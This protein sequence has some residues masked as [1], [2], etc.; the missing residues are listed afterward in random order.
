M[1]LLV[2]R[3]VAAAP[4]GALVPVVRGVSLEID[5]G[6]W[7]ALTGVNGCGKST[8]A[9]ALAGLLPLRAGDV[10]LAGEPLERA[11]ARGEIGVVLQEPSSQLLQPTVGDELAFAAR[12]LGRPDD[13][14]APRLKALSAG[15]G[16]VDDL[17]RDPRVLSAGRQQLVLLGAALVSE[18]RLLVA[19][20]AGAHL[21]AGARARA[22][23]LLD[24][25]V[26]SGLAL[27][28]VTQEATERA[29]ARR[30]LDLGVA[31]AGGTAA[32][33]EWRAPRRD[34]APGHGVVLPTEVALALDVAPGGD[35]DG[36]CVQTRSRLRVEVRTPG[37]TGLAGR[38]GSGKSVLLAAACGLLDLPQIGV[39]WARVPE[40]PPILAAQYPELQIFEERVRDEVAF[41]AVSRGM[42]RERALAEAQQCFGALGL[43]GSGFLGT[44]CWDLSAGER[45]L[46][47]VVAALV[48]PASLVAL[49]EPTAGLDLVRRESLAGM[50]AERAGRDPVLIASQDHPW[51]D[52]VGARTVIVGEGVSDCAKSQQKNGLTEPCRGV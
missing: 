23:D 28:W 47:E 21:D 17:A 11:R 24:R 15:L 3:G 1:S 10:T 5:R 32:A 36:P 46:L 34:A 38:N 6:E 29:R 16:L 12:N 30:T 37:I 2:A 51:L 33:G 39:R 50:V 26:A 14:I 9:L 25:E 45:R 40:V 41:A 42:D 19:D 31:A 7:V 8:L 13:Q 52:R 4:P 22:L 27:L 18:P 43:G 49:D 44:R 20:E 48:A 35:A